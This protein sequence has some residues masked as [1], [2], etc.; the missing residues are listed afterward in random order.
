[1]S[2]PPSNAAAEESGVLM[3]RGTLL[4]TCLA[5]V[6]AATLAGCGG[7]GEPAAPGSS[8]PPVSP[9]VTASAQPPAVVPAS[10]QPS[11]GPGGGSSTCTLD[12]LNVT[13]VHSGAAAGHYG[14]VL[15]FRHDQTPTCRLQGYPGVAALD[16]Q[17][18]QVAQAR[19]TPSGYLGGLADP[20]GQP[21]VVDLAPGGV[22]S[23]LVEGT[24]VPPGGATSC[25]LY[26]GVLVTPPDETHSVRLDVEANG[27][28]G[29]DV[30]PVVPGER[31][32]Q[33]G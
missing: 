27:C 28:G 32:T 15:V 4:T 20:N 21:P 8:T 33:R 10:G 1:M 31:G 22:A 12:H 16:A 14:F 26:Q 23:A 13:L 24:N 7:S 17:G 6:A 30:H 19:R 2:G 18:A 9:P 11:G 25:P 5:T 3:V 29:L